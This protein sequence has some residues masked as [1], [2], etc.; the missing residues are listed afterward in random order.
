[1]L[2]AP[3]TPRAPAAPRG[4]PARRAA[5]RCVGAGWGAARS[6]CLPACLPVA[7]DGARSELAPQALRRANPTHQTTGPCLLEPDGPR[8]ASPPCCLTGAPPPAPQWPTAE[9]CCAPGGSGAFGEGCSTYVPSAP[10]WLIDTYEPRSCRLE[11]D[12]A[13]CS[14]GAA[15]GMGAGRAGTGGGKPAAAAS[16]GRGFG[17][18]AAGSCSAAL[19]PPPCSFRGC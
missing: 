7:E 4:S 9:A 14:R 18:A 1:M 16:G 17:R 8:P 5:R 2:S 19:S 12:I 3:G 6:A 15:R 13:R 10:C 11:R